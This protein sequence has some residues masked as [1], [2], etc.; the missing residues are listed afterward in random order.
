MEDTSPWA[1]VWDQALDL[2]S[3][4][5]TPAWETL[6]QYIPLLL[7]GLLALS[8]LGIVWVWRRNAV[9]NRSRV[10]APMPAGPVPE[11]VH[12]PPGSIWPFI[13]PIGLFLVVL[14]LALGGGE[15]G[16]PINLALA[17]V[18]LLVFLVA[19]AGWYVDANREY[20]VLDAHDHGLTLPAQ[21]GSL[22]PRTETIPEGVHLPGPSA[23]PFL[24]PIGLVFMFLGLELGPLLI[25]GGAFM[26]IAAGAGWYIDANREYQ[27][28]EATGHPAEP[29]T[30]DPVK[31][32]PRWAAPTF[33][34]VGGFVILLT[35]FPWF[36][37]LI[38]EQAAEG[39]DVGPP[40]TTTP[41]LSASTATH[42]DQGRIV[43]P[44]DTPVT[45]TFQNDQ[46]GVPHDVAIASEAEPDTWL[47]NGDDITGVA[48]I[49]YQLPPFAAGEYTFHCTIHPPMVG[50]V[51]VREAPPPPP[52]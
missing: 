10:P 6:L 15:D 28:V 31:V 24:A 34:A 51:L 47:F 37:S 13:A 36:L 16:L 38:P 43:I 32:F 4:F 5:V 45:L 46:A 23:W 33:A 2:V 12:L 17:S 52:A 1:P 11:G 22:V 29:L 48:T 19:A 41:F 18:G 9:V 44:A 30:R 26:A 49:D 8:L 27:Q 35:L 3:R 25:V 50:T 14:A 40:P 42:F 39:G 21:A 20:D 7:I